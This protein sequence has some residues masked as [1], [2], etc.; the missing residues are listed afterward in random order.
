MP[1]QSPNTEST[2]RAKTG[3]W[4]FATESTGAHVGGSAGMRDWSIEWVLKRNCSM[5][6]RQLFGVFA[7]L[8]AV[9]IAIAGFFWLQG[10]TMIA[11]FAGL[12]LLTVATCL[13]LYSRH[14]ADYENIAMRAGLLTVRHTSGTRVEI[15]EFV[16]EWVRV[17]PVSNDQSLI[18]LSGQGKKI[19]VGRFIR[20]ELRRQLANELRHA[21]RVA[22]SQPPTARPAA[23]I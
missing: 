5:A 9:S 19:E 4:H 10:A 16:P 11:P 13:L 3:A 6:P 2:K 22:C 12:E 14:A 1:V 21:V 17:E 20:P 18:Q 23:Q 15:A 7:A 8:C